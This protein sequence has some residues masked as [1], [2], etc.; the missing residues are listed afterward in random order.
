MAGIWAEVLGVDR[1]AY[2]NFL[3]LGGDSI[4]VLVVAAGRRPRS[5][6]L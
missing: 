4:R 1:V 3:D 2:D 6:S 5:T